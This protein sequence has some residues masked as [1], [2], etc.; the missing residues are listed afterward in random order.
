MRRGLHA[1]TALAV[2]SLALVAGCGSSGSK[3]S[4][5]GASITVWHGYTDVENTEIVALAGKWNAQ[6]PTEKVN[7]VFDG[8]NDSALQ[9]TTAALAAG[10]YPDLAYEYGSSATDLVKKKQLVDLT[11]VVKGTGWDWNDFFASERQAAT[12]D[13]K[14]VGLP[15]LVD[16]LALVYNKKLFDQAG[17]AYPTASWTWDDF[18][19]AAL[20]LTSSSAKTYGWAYVNDGSED[21]VWR[22]LAMLWQSGG[23]LLNP[24]GKASAIDSPAGLK[25]MQLL[26]D[27]AVTDKSVYLDTGSGNYLNLFNS[28]K[29]GMLWTGP[30][31]L[32]SIDPSV[33]YGTEELP[34]SPGGTHAS[35]SGPDSWMVFDN[36]KKRVATAE[37]FLQWLLSPTIHL[38]WA[39]ATG[40]LPVRTSEETSPDFATYLQKYP[41]DKVFVANMNN[42]TK[43]RPNIA[44]YPEISAAIGQAVQSVLLGKSTPAG[45]LAQATKDVNGVFAESG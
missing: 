2:A 8:G 6:H 7:L 13:G 21:T 19:A 9:K 41:G 22:Y 24:A 35:I 31:D 42:V 23:D 10:K 25:A 14:I 33:S 34:A 36:G 16:N 40:D 28:G 1:T 43:S 4:A 26:H 5:G 17:L 3:S 12:V 38:E 32:S 45:A 37:A 20:K 39:M 29:I 11:S 18:R 15:A 44:Q 27:M 30:W